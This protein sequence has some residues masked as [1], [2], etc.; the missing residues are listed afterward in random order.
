MVVTGSRR[1]AKAPTV[2]NWRGHLHGV[3]LLEPPSP[4]WCA[5]E[6]Q[7]FRCRI[8]LVSLPPRFTGWR[9]PLRWVS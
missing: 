8:A 7:Q 3:G 2:G 9:S 6:V 4:S 1:H 5:V